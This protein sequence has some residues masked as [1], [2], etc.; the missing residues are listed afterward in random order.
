MTAAADI[1]A[2]VLAGQISPILAQVFAIIICAGI[3]TSAVPLLWTG[4][5]KVS[6]EGTKKY[7]II[8]IAGGVIGCIVACFIPY[9]GLINVL[10]GMN[11]YLGFVLIFFMLVYDTKTKMSRKVKC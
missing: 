2:L 4:V 9:K 11:G 8:T 3:Y 6:N 1:P 10:Y 7:R 5:R